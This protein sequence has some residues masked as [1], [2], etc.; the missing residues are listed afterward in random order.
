MSAGEWVKRASYVAN[1]WRIVER[2][3]GKPD[4]CV[5]V[6]RSEADADRIVNSAGQLRRFLLACRAAGSVN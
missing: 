5:A 6:V 3:P 2:R 1:T 4:R